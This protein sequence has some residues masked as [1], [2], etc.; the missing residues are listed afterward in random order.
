MI[1]EPVAP[2][3]APKPMSN[4]PPLHALDPRNNNVLPLESALVPYNPENKQQHPNELNFDLLE[5]ITDVEDEQLVLSVTQF[6]EQN[7]SMY[8]F[9]TK[10]M[11]KRNSPRKPQIFAGCTSGSIETHNIHTISINSGFERTLCAAKYNIL[12][13]ILPLIF[14]KVYEI[15][16]K[17]YIYMMF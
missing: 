1:N 8:T 5:M 2:Q 3:M 10:V 11:A 6:K 13:V 14:V 16:L 12:S 15:Y 4:E 7:Q 17:C 9:T